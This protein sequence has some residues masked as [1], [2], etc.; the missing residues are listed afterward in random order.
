M[1]VIAGTSNVRAT[2]TQIV[3]PISKHRVV[4]NEVIYNLGGTDTDKVD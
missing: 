1:F 3:I 2:R 4:I